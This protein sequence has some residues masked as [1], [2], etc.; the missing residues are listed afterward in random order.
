[1][2]TPISNTQTVSQNGTKPT[3]TIEILDSSPVE[4]RRPLSLING[5]SYCATW[6][7]VR[8][9]ITEKALP[10]GSTLTF[11]PPKEE[12]DT[13]LYIVTSDGKLYG[14]GQESLSKLPI[15][16][17]LPEIPPSTKLW[18][19]VS[20]KAFLNGYKA[21][22]VDV[23]S[24]V[25]SVI[26][27]FLA[28]DRSLA[29]QKDMAELVGCFVMS[30][31]FLDAFS[32]TGYLWSN[33]N[34]GSGKTQLLNIVAEL[35][36]L[37][38]VIMNGGSYATLRDLADYGACLAFDDIESLNDK[39]FDPDKKALLLAGNRRGATVTLKELD[40]NNKWRTRYVNSFC[41][42]VFS[43]ISLPDSVLASRSIIVP[44]VRTNDREKAN[45][46]VSRYKSWPCDR[47]TLIDDLWNIALC[48]LPELPA[49]EEKVDSESS[50]L[51][52]NLEPFRSIL[53]IAKWLDD[54]GVTGLYQRMTKLSED[55][56]GEKQDLEVPD[57][58]LLTLKAIVLSLCTSMNVPIVPLVPDVP[59]IE[60]HSFFF[61]AKDLQAFA[62]IIAQDDDDEGEWITIKKVGRQLAKL[63]FKQP[64]R[65][66]GQG[67]RQ[68]GITAKELLAI[69][70]AYSVPHPF[71]LDTQDSNGTNG[72]TGTMAQIEEMPV[73]EGEI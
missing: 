42:R 36:Y 53:A 1:M 40:G 73:L 13:E 52:R 49:Y 26:D 63:R 30:S 3:N 7:P 15:G 64:P 62:V 17:N 60:R 61:T 32:V 8:K 57:L 35:S 9:W 58:T 54:H 27:R 14:A 34:K 50:L 48:H 67:S 70:D 33:G 72:T 41:P 71:V 10:D 37:G 2:T 59:L 22:P 21:N 44:L 46:D 11:D 39:K 29:E 31:Y 28:F 19:P 24:R 65:S 5:K 20:V 47:Q 66:G 25:V 69:L 16:V 18:S 6:L 4:M 55:Y 43:A 23:F 38:I 51:G 12:F 56:Q 45:S 68:W